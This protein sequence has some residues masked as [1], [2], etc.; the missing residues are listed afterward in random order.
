MKKSTC[1]FMAIILIFSLC[2]CSS[3]GKQSMS[4][5]PSEFSKETREV[6]EL[7]KDELQFFDISFDESAKYFKI[8]L[9]VKCGG[10]WIE[11]GCT[12]DEVSFLTER[13]AVRLTEDCFELYRIDDNGYIKS[14]YP[15]ETDFDKSTAFFGTKIDSETPLELNKELALWAKYGTEKTSIEASGTLHDFRD[16]DCSAGTIVVLTVSDAPLD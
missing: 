16:V 12:S 7:F 4:V 6:L 11:H 2:A 3:S 14:S 1:L 5:K 13:I 8:S 10:E 9:W 15:L